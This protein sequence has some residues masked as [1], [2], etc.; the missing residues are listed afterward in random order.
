[1]RRL[2]DKGRYD[3]RT[4]ETIIDAAPYVHVAAVVDE[5]AMCLPTMHVRRD[6]TLV[7]HGS[8]SNGVLT[9]VL[10]A[11]WASLTFTHY[12]GVRLARS[13]FESSVAYRSAVVEGPTRE[14][15]GS[16]RDEALTLF[17]ERALPGRSQQV[18][19]MTSREANLTLVVEVH[20][21]E[22]SAKLSAGP[23]SD[24]GDDL[25]AP[26]WS[27]V[28]PVRTVKTR[29]VPS[30]DGAMA[31]GLLE[32]PRWSDAPSRER[33]NEIDQLSDR[34]RELVARDPRT[35]ASRDAMLERLSWG[36]DC[37]DETIDPRHVTAS[38]FVLSS[39]GV[40]L[41]RHRLLDIC[42]Q[43]GGHVDPGETSLEA[44]RREVREETGLDARHLEVPELFHV[45]VHLGPRGH[46]HYDLRYL[47]IAAPE[48]PCPPA[49][50]SPDVYWFE[51]EAALERC[52]ESLRPALTALAGH[53]LWRDLRG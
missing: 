3:R 33:Q 36:D 2:P 40:L 15:V 47:M 31:E 6:D 11:G 14:L 25:L 44:A 20:I 37:F 5:R 12:D 10:R 39:R 22:A 8:R 46:T 52:H 38:A 43:P 45:D 21:D 17:V 19:P 26:V 51:P 48:D 30:F 50:E 24:E 49:D 9:S 16:E 27:G 41:H 29:P 23:T 18:R 13:G 32:A 7:L 42:V 34:V 35:Q 53:P 4:I 1:L 28:L